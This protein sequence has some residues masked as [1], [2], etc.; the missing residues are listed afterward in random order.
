MT[1]SRAADIARAEKLV[2]EALAASPRSALVH[3][4]KGHL[5]RAQRR[6][7]EAIPEFET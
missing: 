3:F 5:L 7:E 1:T 4:V 6:P 2:S